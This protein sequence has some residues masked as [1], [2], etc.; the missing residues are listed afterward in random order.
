L[1]TGLNA[2]RDIPGQFFSPEDFASA[3]AIALGTPVTGFPISLTLDVSSSL[4]D[5]GSLSLGNYDLVIGNA[6]LSSD[7]AVL[8]PFAFAAQAVPEP[9][10][11]TLF[12]AG[13]IG[14]LLLRGRRLA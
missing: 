4:F 1:L 11:I 9:W 7:P 13:L 5:L 14:L 8:F 10:S 12:A 3:T 2:Y 6:A